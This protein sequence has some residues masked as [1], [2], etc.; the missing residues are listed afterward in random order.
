[1]NL[2]LN[3]RLQTL[4]RTAQ[5]LGAEQA[6]KIAAEFKVSVADVESAFA[7][8]QRALQ[9][10]VARN[11]DAGKDTAALRKNSAGGAFQGQATVNLSSSPALRGFNL[12]VS[13][14]AQ[15]LPLIQGYEGLAARAAAG[16]LSTEAAAAAL[17]TLVKSAPGNDAATQS[18]WSKEGE[19]LRHRMR[20]ALDTLA[21]AVP[22]ATVW[23][24]PDGRAVNVR[25]TAIQEHMNE[26]M[27]SGDG[28]EKK[29]WGAEFLKHF[30]NDPLAAFAR[31]LVSGEV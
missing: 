2:A 28:A 6:Q 31:N 17:Q 11:E 8:Q 27:A 12:Q 10:G 22:D 5:P 9:S 24:T 25:Y 1:M 18:L 15:F 16:T 3:N 7:A 21:A 4:A 13:P 20:D 23:Q 30:A 14:S 26:A 19:P 29:K